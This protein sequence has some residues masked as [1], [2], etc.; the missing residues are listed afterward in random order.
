[1]HVKTTMREIYKPIGIAALKKKHTNTKY[2]VNKSL[3]LSSKDK[4][5]HAL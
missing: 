4:N 5:L 1:M 2:F 3:A